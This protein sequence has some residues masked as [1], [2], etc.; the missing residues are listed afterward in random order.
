MNDKVPSKITGFFI[1]VIGTGIL[2]RLCAVIVDTVFFSNNEFKTVRYE[3][4]GLIV[5]VISLLVGVT[6]LLR[7]KDISK[8]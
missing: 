2:L 1:A 7:V 3:N 5:F 4:Y 8:E 6:W